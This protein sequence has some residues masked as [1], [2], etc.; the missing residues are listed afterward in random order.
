MSKRNLKRGCRSDRLVLRAAPSRE[1]CPKVLARVDDVSRSR[2]N[3]S[4]ERFRQRLRQRR[5][6]T[7]PLRDTPRINVVDYTRSTRL[8]TYVTPR[9][10]A[11]ARTQPGL[12]AHSDCTLTP[13]TAYYGR[14]G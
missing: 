10:N 11:C 9:F 13:R 14:R 4:L 3:V 8:P 6:T 2:A 12:R 5:S 7:H 1:E